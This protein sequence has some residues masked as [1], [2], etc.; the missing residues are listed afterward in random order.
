[1]KELLSGH[2]TAK[3]LFQLVSHIFLHAGLAHLLLNMT[4]LF[5]VGPYV[6]EK[7]GAFKYLVIYLLSGFFS[8]FL[9]SI[10][11]LNVKMVMIGASGAICGV[12]AAAPFV[13]PKNHILMMI[14]DYFTFLT[15]LRLQPFS[16]YVISFSLV[17]LAQ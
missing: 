9:M 6:E 13:A 8:A 14:P 5:A 15:T 3:G 10:P 12:A 1:M 7:L 16:L 11:Y 4:I 17:L 2:I